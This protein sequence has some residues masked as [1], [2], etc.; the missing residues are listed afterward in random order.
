MVRFMTRWLLGKD[1]PFT[2]E[3]LKLD[4]EADLRCTRTGQ[5]LEDFKGKSCFDLNRE[6]ALELAK[7]RAKAE[8]S[9]DELRAKVSRLIGMQLPVLAATM[10]HVGTI[11]RDTYRLKS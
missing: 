4:S 5:V 3:A 2:E 6:R 1:E 7:L 8:P 11:V 9:G 10:K